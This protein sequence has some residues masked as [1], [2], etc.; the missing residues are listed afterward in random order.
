MKATIFF[1]IN[2]WAPSNSGR[3]RASAFSRDVGS[4]DWHC[5]APAVAERPAVP[6]QGSERAEPPWEQV[7]VGGDG[8][9][10]CS[11]VSGKWEVSAAGHSRTGMVE[12][13]GEILSEK[14]RKWQNPSQDLSGC[15][16]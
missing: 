14:G 8:M 4:F 15:F 13:G 7:G 1:C 10:G 3:N 5:F 16:L 11:S 6:R 2:R 12:A 9:L